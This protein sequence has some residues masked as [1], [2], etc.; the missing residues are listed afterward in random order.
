[1]LSSASVVIAEGQ[2][3]DMMFEEEDEVSIDEYLTMIYKKTGALFEASAVLGGLVATS[4]DAVLGKLAEFGKN[5]G[6]A[7]QIRDDILGIVGKEE[8]LG[9]PV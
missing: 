9:K 4:D 2:A 3:M 1:M 8:E 7:F 5:L 6:I